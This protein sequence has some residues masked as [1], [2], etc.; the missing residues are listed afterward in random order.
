MYNTLNYR[1]W[2]LFYQL[3]GWPI[4]N[5]G[6]WIRRQSYSE[7]VSHCCLV[8]PEHHQHPCHDVRFQMWTIWIWVKALS[9]CVTF[10]SY[11]PTVWLF[12][13]IKNV[14]PLPCYL[15]QY[16]ILQMETCDFVNNK[17]FENN[18]WQSKWISMYWK[19]KV[20]LCVKTCKK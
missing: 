4:A 18:W 7:N 1:Y 3:S 2:D 20:L 10:S 17:I 5:F 6:P 15:D 13:Y 11:C 19:R 14:K 12:L 16:T 9:Y 8:G